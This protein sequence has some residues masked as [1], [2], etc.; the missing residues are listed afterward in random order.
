MTNA[1]GSP[2]DECR[3]PQEPPNEIRL[4]NVEFRKKPEFPKPE[5]ASEARR[6]A[7]CGVSHSAACPVPRLA[8]EHTSALLQVPPLRLETTRAPRNSRRARRCCCGSFGIRF[9]AYFRQLAFD[10]RHLRSSFSGC[11]WRVDSA[12][13]M[14]I[15]LLHGKGKGK[16]IL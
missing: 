13:R 5:T 16:L 14:A 4:M 6:C 12:R 11:P 8:S 7:D 10:I 2:N 15:F 1:R 9:S 3:I